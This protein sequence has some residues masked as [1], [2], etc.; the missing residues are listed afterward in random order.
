MAGDCIVGGGSEFDFGDAGDGDL[1]VGA[2]EEGDADSDVGGAV[3]GDLHDLCDAV[4]AFETDDA[5]VFSDRE[6]G[7]EVHIVFILTEH[8][9]QETHLGIGDDGEGA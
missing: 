7:G 3:L 4:V 6:L 5:D 2:A 1:H 8:G 9:F